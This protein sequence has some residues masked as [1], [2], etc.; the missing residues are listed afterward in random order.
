MWELWLKMD[1]RF[2]GAHVWAW[3]QPHRVRGSVNQCYSDGDMSVWGGR[4]GAGPE[5][6]EGHG[7]IGCEYGIS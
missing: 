1:V 5:I 7:I 2:G 6:R 4:I 3:Y